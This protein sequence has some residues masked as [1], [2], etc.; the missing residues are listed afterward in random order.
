MTGRQS[1][2]HSDGQPLLET[3]NGLLVDLDGVILL[4]DRLVDGAAAA[5]RDVRKAGVPLTFVTNNASRLPAELVRRLN[6]AEV[7]AEPAEVVTAAQAAADRLAADM[8]TGA[9]VLVVGGPGLR[10]AVEDVGLRVSR[11]ADPTPDAVVQGWGPDVGWRELAEAT[12]AVRAGAPW[13]VTNRDR[14]LPT[15]RGELPGSGALIAAVVTALGR[16]PDLVVGKPERGLFDLALRRLGAP[17]R[18]LMVGDRPDTDIGGAARAGIPSLLVLTGVADAADVLNAAPEDR[19]AYLGRDVRALADCHPPV[20][21]DGHTASC[22]GTTVRLGHD[23]V[24]VAGA[25]TAPS[26]GLDGLRAAA[27]L[28]WS[29]RLRPEEH[30]GVLERLDLD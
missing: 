13:V 28:A 25:P 30:Q 7:P 5:L 6:D 18:P 12:V 11:S 9:T 10:A 21:V 24:Q 22:R 19:P 23:G 20:L 26:D 16:E 1:L 2:D 14:T 3:V 4:G 27:V 8:P 17:T 15:G 29:G